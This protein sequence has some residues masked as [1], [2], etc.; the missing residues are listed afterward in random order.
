MEKAAT[1]AAAGGQ[2]ALAGR[3]GDSTAT[4]WATDTATAARVL[5]RLR[6]SM[7]GVDPLSRHERL[8]LPAD[9]LERRTSTL[10]PVDG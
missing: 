8:G 6:A 3:P 4:R 9:T 10:L 5:A 1:T 2:D 7:A